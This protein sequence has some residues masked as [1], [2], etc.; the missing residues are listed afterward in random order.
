[1]NV[2]PPTKSHNPKH[3]KL[4]EGVDVLVGPSDSV[5]NGRR[6]MR[7]SSFINRNEVQN[8]LSDLGL[9]V[10]KVLAERSSPSVK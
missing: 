1:M 5:V 3:V 7:Q 2:V 4:P 8:T 10:L 9:R 6:K